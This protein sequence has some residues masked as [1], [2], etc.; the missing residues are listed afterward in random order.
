MASPEYEAIQ[1]DRQ[2]TAMIEGLPRMQRMLVALLKKSG[3]DPADYWD[4]PAAEPEGPVVNP[5]KPADGAPGVVTEEGGMV[6]VGEPQP[7]TLVPSTTEELD[8]IQSGEKTV[9]EVEGERRELAQALAE[10]RSPVKGEASEDWRSTPLDEL[11]LDGPTLHAL[12]DEELADAGAVADRLE[13]FGT[14]P[15]PGIGETRLKNLKA[16]IDKVK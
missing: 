7:T 14:E 1:N 2:R 12:R 8:A 11:G 10:S 4:E 13:R 3:L 16:A 5:I 6:V 9:E 15:I